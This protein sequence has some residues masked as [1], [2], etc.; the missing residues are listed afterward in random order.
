[1]LT[2][3]AHRFAHRQR[4]SVNPPLFILLAARAQILVQCTEVFYFWQ[5]HQMVPPEVAHFAFH[6]TLLVAPRRIAKLRLESPMRTKG[7]QPIRLL[8]LVAAQN[9]LHRAL[10]VVVTQSPEHSAE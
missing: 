3:D 7:D 8:S 2:L 5:R 4:L 9:L 10:Q 1:M 6:A